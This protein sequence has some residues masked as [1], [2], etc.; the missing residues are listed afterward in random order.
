MRASDLWERSRPRTNQ[1]LAQTYSR[2][3]P[4]PLLPLPER[5]ASGR[6]SFSPPLTSRNRPIRSPHLARLRSVVGRNASAGFTRPTPAL[7]EAICGSGLDREQT[8]LRR[9][10][11]AVKTAPTGTSVFSDRCA[12]GRMS[13]SPPLTSRNRPNRSPHLAQ[14]RSVVGCNASTGF[15]RPTPALREAICGSGLDREQTKLRRSPIR[16]QDRSHRHLCLW[17][18]GVPLDRMSSAHHL[19]VE[20]PTQHFAAS[21]AAAING[22]LKCLGGFHPPYACGA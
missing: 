5:C 20:K 6:M 21:C 7:R 17:L 16:G 19:L 2:S 13:F 9:R 10:L 11:F 15:T 14:L 22:W 3:R 8:G 18:T 4:L 1:A 12:S